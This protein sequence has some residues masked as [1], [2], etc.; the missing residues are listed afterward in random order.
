VIAV[1]LEAIS[2]TATWMG[3]KRSALW[4]L[5]KCLNFD[6]VAVFGSPRTKRSVAGHGG[7]GVTAAGALS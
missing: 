7:A 1:A 5:K 4:T 6:G 2:T 3:R